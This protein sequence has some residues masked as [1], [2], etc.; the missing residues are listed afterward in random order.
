MI[1]KPRNR[2]VCHIFILDTDILGGTDFNYA[3]TIIEDRGRSITMDWSQG[4][5][6]EDMELLGYSV[7]LYPAEKEAK[8]QS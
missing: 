5:L 2:N 8:E 7:R 4:G 1:G 6:N 3:E